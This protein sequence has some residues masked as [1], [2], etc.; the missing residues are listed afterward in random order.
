MSTVVDLYTIQIMDDGMAGHWDHIA[1]EKLVRMT[2][3]PEA[4]ENMNTLLSPLGYSAR[5][6]RWDHSD[7]DEGTD[8]E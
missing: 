3:M 1:A 6:R 5:I 2:L 8:D 4:E 7:P